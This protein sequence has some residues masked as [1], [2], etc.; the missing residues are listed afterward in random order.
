[1]LTIPL[2]YLSKSQQEKYSKTDVITP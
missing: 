1:V 2:K